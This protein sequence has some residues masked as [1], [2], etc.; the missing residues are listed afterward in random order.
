[1][2]KIA[3]LS[4][5]A[6]FA[7][8]VLSSFVKLNNQP[9]NNLGKNQDFKN[10]VSGMTNLK[11]NLEKTNTKTAFIGFLKKTNTTL[12]NE[13]LAKALGYKNGEELNSNYVQLNSYVISFIKATPELATDKA[14]NIFNEAL[15]ENL[16]DVP[17]CFDEWSLAVWNCDSRYPSSNHDDP[18]VLFAWNNCMNMAYYAF[19]ACSNLPIE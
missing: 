9:E 1:M 3:L 16:Q 13:N 2:K 4:I 7:F 5:I 17:N 12:Q 15:K 6:V 19:I 10:W 14:Q 11:A 18:N 8:I